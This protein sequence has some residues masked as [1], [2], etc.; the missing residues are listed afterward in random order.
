M[1]IKPFR[2]GLPGTLG[3]GLAAAL[4]GMAFLT[5]DVGAQSAE[6]C[7]VCHRDIH[8]QWQE[9]RHAQSWKSQ[10]FQ[11]QMKSFGSERACGS[12]HAPSSIWQQLELTPSD[13]SGQL[14]S[15]DALLEEKPKYRG[16]ETADEGVTCSSCHVIEVVRPDSKG[17]DYIGPYH[18][19]EAHQGNEV[20]DF[21]N[22]QLCSSCHGRAPSDYAA[23]TQDADYH[24]QTVLEYDFAFGKVDCANCHM[25][26]EEA[27]L[28]QFA[29]YRHLPER[30]VGEHRFVG[31]RYQELQ[32]ALEMT[33]STQG[34]KTT[35][36]LT[37]ARIGHPLR[38]NAKTSYRLEMSLMSGDSAVESAS[39]DLAQAASLD[40]G[41]T[42]R[43]EVPFPTAPTST[44]KVELF[45]REGELWEAKVFTKTF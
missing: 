38:I 13:R 10:I 7:A 15:F 43:L 6:A 16:A 36:S 8:D 18:T 27:R 22:Y 5:V 23:G 31:K 3:T 2:L 25:P 26:R 1:G 28:V 4:L 32:T 17:P 11:A 42:I 12:C 20:V 39:V 37:N 33:V 34:G 44:L 24:H 45:R 41:E 40:L 21:K 9:S 35:L 29:G 14:A 19:T 30:M